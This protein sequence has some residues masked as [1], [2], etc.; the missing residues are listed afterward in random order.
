MES[1][2]KVI[3][4]FPLADTVNSLEWMVREMNTYFEVTAKKYRLEMEAIL[5]E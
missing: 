1:L 3:Q 2:E 4:E 5:E